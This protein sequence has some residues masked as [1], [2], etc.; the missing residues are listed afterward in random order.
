M[1]ADPL[2]EQ[3]R[4]AAVRGHASAQAYLGYCYREGIGVARDDVEAVK[5]FRKAAEQGH[6]VAQYNLGMYYSDNEDVPK[7]PDPVDA[8]MTWGLSTLGIPGGD[9][10]DKNSA[11]AVRWFRKAA[12][13]GNPDAQNKLGC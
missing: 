9:G 8:I 11:E 2:F 4:A 6:E 10:A 7:H 1:D 13:Q 3:Y 5:W 12:E